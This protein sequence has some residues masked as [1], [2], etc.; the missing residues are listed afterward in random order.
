MC[1]VIDLIMGDKYR[2]RVLKNGGDGDGVHAR[3][4][5]FQRL[6]VVAEGTI[7]LTRRHQLHDVDLR[8]AHFNVDVEAGVLYSPWPGPD[9]SRRVPPGHTSW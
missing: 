8:A 1:R 3:L 7:R 9:R 6:A 2:W 5:G 4:P